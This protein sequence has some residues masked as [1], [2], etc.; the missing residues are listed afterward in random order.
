LKEQRDSISNAIN[1]YK[2]LEHI[3]DTW[4]LAQLTNTN[5][6]LLGYKG[7]FFTLSKKD[8]E[9]DSENRGLD[10][11]LGILRDLFKELP[12]N[13]FLDSQLWDFL[14]EVKAEGLDLGK[15]DDADEKGSQERLN[16][17]QRGMNHL[18][19]EC[20]ALEHNISDEAER[21]N[22]IISRRIVVCNAVSIVLFSFGW[23]LGLTRGTSES[24]E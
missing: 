8:S 19:S 10:Y 14:R 13:K 22:E 21:A 6:N 5:L 18:E 20:E 9:L 2:V 1:L 15:V 12:Y 3:H 4:I 7:V 24:D 17:A 23:M 11:R 16:R